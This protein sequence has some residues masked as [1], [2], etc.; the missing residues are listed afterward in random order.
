MVQDLIVFLNLTYVMPK[1]QLF[2]H[3]QIFILF[4]GQSS[5]ET[6]VFMFIPKFC[7]SC[8]GLHILGCSTLG[9]L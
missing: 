8:L 6:L 1:Q 2:L 4:L 9:H 3:I 5:I 7:N